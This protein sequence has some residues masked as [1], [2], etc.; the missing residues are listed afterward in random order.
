LAIGHP[1]IPWNTLWDIAHGR[2]PKNPIVRDQLGYTT[3][4]SCGQCWRFN[5]YIKK[6][7]PRV[8]KRWDQLSG[9]ALRF[10]F[11]HREEF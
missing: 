6:T 9:K 10:A 4:P 3:L 7:R 8:I 5:K 11:E 2:E 1:D